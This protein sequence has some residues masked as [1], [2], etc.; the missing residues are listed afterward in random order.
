[1]F[2]NRIFL[3]FILYFTGTLANANAI[4]ISMRNPIAFMLERGFRL[5]FKVSC[6]DLSSTVSQWNGIGS[7]VPQCNKDGGFLQKQCHSSTGFCWC[8]DVNGKRLSEQVRAWELKGLECS[9]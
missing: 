1:M 4:P 6:T 7:F 3:C 9:S 5:G 8:S 2:F